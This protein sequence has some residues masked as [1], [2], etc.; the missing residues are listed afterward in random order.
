MYL[1][2]ERPDGRYIAQP[3]ALVWEPLQ[4]GAAPDP[5]MIF[6]HNRGEQFLKSMADELARAGFRADELKAKDT[7]V[8][9]VKYH[10]EDMRKLVF[11]FLPPAQARLGIDPSGVMAALKKEVDDSGH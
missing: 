3:V 4:E 8:E 5:T 6:E 7:Q 10:L 2:D 11:S 9:A 1:V